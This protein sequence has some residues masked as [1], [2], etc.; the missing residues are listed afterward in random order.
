MK[1]HLL[2]TV[3]SGTAEQ[4]RN[5]A[6]EYLQVYILRL[7]HEA[8]AFRNLAFLGGTALRLIH[9]LPRFSEDLDFSLATPGLDAPALFER[10]GNN[11]LEAGYALTTRPRARG[12]VASVF[13]AFHDL[14]RELGW[15]TDPR[16]RFSVKL[17][18][19][20]DPPTGAH[21]ETTLVQRFFP[22]ALRHHDLPSLFAG[23][24]HAILTRPYTKGR[25][26]F[27]LVW[28]LTEHR[29]L[30]PNLALLASALSQTGHGDLDASS[31]R[32]LAR[33]R[34]RRI[35]WPRVLD[36]LRPFVERTGDLDHLQLELVEKLLS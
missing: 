7:L 32:S 34:L 12:N 23:K 9:G 5:L 13:Y 15:S 30:E 1:D 31:W 18:I 25:D 17:E 29:G 3:S 20:L 28:Y 8:G 27:D 35:R 16:A 36:E 21:V 19:D 11:L 14:P 33:R 26:W 4:R 6:R 10:A 22:V 2:Q 24:L